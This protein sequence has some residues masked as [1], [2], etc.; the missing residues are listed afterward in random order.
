MNHFE[1]M[2]DKFSEENKRKKNIIGISNLRNYTK[3]GEGNEEEENRERVKE[4]QEEE[5]EEERTK[6]IVKKISI[7]AGMTFNLMTSKH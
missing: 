4:K 5:K 6:K 7:T 2:S 1:Y 3:E